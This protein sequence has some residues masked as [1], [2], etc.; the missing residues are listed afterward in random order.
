MQ[1]LAERIR[2]FRAENGLTA[3]ALM[4]QIDPASGNYLRVYQWESRTK[5]CLPS[6]RALARLAELGVISFE[7]RDQIVFGRSSAA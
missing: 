5:P 2:T 7:E 3:R 1:D 4:Q 6:K